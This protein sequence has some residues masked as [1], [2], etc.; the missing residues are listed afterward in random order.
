MFRL[1]IEGL[2]DALLQQLSRWCDA[3]EIGYWSLT[4]R[5]DDENGR[6]EVLEKLRHTFHALEPYLR[7]EQAPRLPMSA[8]RR[9]VPRENAP[10]PA[11]STGEPAMPSPEAVAG[12]V[13]A[14][15]R[16]VCERVGR[17][18]ALLRLR[19]SPMASKGEFRIGSADVMV[20]DLAAELSRK[21]APAASSTAQTERKPPFE[22]YEVP[23]PGLHWRALGDSWA[24]FGNTV[25]DTV[26]SMHHITR[27][28]IAQT[29]EENS[30]L[31]VQNDVLQASV[32]ELY[33]SSMQRVSEQE[34][35]G[36]ELAKLALARDAVGKGT[37]AF[38]AF[39]AT[40]SESPEAT[41]LFVLL[42]RSP[43]LMSA[44]KDPRVRHLLSQPQYLDQLADL[45]LGFASTLGSAS[46]QQSS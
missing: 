27:Q 29:Q 23:E 14:W 3:E 10:G 18:R 9:E 24:Q 42:S 13:L 38:M 22:G 35:N 31:R 7:A 32:I 36:T 4:E 20:R 43:K 30:A 45:V 16:Q 25:M 5:V 21:Q 34:R 26:S 46:P 40:K 39:L 11:E 8:R 41:Q 1:S 2:D 33:K 37:E 28:Q 15:V 6:Y 19:L 12:A 17:G 44:L